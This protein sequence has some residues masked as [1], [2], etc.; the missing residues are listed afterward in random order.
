MN[1]PKK[2]YGPFEK[3]TVVYIY[4]TCY[5]CMSEAL[6]NWM[7][8]KK[9]D[10]QRFVSKCM[11]MYQVMKYIVKL[12]SYNIDLYLLPQGQSCWKFIHQMESQLKIVLRLSWFH[13][14]ESELFA[15][16]PKI[17]EMQTLAISSKLKFINIKRVLPQ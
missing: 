9:F 12:F 10:L 4:V 7:Q 1:Q 5:A 2:T 3:L 14:F 6:K 15:K 8:D 17:I 16:S 13:T 11:F